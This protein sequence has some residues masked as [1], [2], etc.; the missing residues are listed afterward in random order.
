[1]ELNREALRALRE[2][3]GHS[4]QSLAI[5]AG[6]SRTMILRLENGERNCRPPVMKKLADALDVPIRALMGEAA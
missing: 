4:Q 1:M 3:H 2:E 5:A 6:V